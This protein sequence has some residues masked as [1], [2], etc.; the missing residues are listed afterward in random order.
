MP[1]TIE[2]SD[3]SGS[4]I[5]IIPAEAVARARALRDLTDPA[6]GPHAMQRLLADI[7]EELAR[8]WH[9]QSIL[10]RSDPVVSV[11]DCYDAL[12][13]PTDAVTRETRYTRYVGADRVLRTHT[14]AMIPPLLRQLAQSHAPARDTLLI[15]PGLAY[16]RDTIDRLHVGEPHQCDLWRIRR[17]RELG[18]DDLREMII[19]VLHAAL[20]ETPWRSERRAH[21]YT[22]GGQQIDVWMNGE[23]VEVLECGL[24]SPRLLDEAGL[25]PRSWSGLAMG[26]GLDRLLMLR[27]GIDDIRLLRSDDARVTAQMLDL[28]P[29]RPVSNQPAIRRDLSIAVA[30][31]TLAEEIGDRVRSA[32]G[33]SVDALEAVEIVTETAGNALPVQARER[34][35]LGP[36]QKNVLLRLVIRHPTMTLTAEQ[37]NVIRDQVYAAVHEGTISQWATTGTTEKGPTPGSASVD[38]ERVQ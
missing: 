13:Y 15:C 26:I 31:D 6:A 16:R 36:G 22:L 37:A 19:R 30:V 28:A 2:R 23:W 38:A 21:P 17:G 9:A 12:H 5:R 34:I 7:R 18:P 25:S 32:M 10:H 8:A 20:P 33:V 27:K 29:Y 14:T 24:A 11:R 35:G 4:P 1:A 3:P